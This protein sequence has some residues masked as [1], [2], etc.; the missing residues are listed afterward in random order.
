MKLIRQ[1]SNFK[2]LRT[3]ILFGFISVIVCIL[4]MSGINYSL[5]S[6]TN[7]STKDML[8]IDLEILNSNEDTVTALL[9]QVAAARGYLLSGDESYKDMFYTYGEKVPELRDKVMSLVDHKEFNKNYTR[10]IEWGS[11]VEENVLNVYDAGNEELALKNMRSVDKELTEIRKKYEELAD[12]R[13]SKIKDTGDSIIK[14]GD[15]S[16]ILSF[17]ITFIVIILST[18]IALLTAK[19]ITSPINRITERMKL[20]AEGDVSLPELEVLSRDEVGTLTKAVNM[21]S[22][23]MQ[24]VLFKIQD[25]SNHV[26][27]NSEELTQSASEIKIGAE[28][29]ALTMHELATGTEAQASNASDLATVMIEFS[30]KIQEANASGMEIE[31]NTDDLLKLAHDG[32]ELMAYSTSQM[33]KIDETVKESVLKIEGLNEQTKEI[34]QLVS[35]INDIANQTNLLALN[36]A[37]EAAR[38]GEHGKG[39]AVVADEVRKL[40]EQVSSSVSHISQIVSKIQSESNDVTDSLRIGYQ[41]VENGSEKISQTNEKFN[42]INVALNSIASNIVNVTT[43]LRDIEANSLTINN[44]VDEIASISQESAAG[45]EETSA[46]VEETSSSMD[47][48]S[49][50]SNQLAIMA[51]DLSMQLSKFKV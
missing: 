48:I 9:V 21:M 27:S 38:A 29:V 35:V 33:K 14:S 45:L 5:T 23:N 32:Q 30:G 15:S 50:S 36:A 37:I 16:I 41:Q 2:K 7:K 18:V 1:L 26:A 34:S 46:T 20:V 51:E 13:F 11:Y 44:A 22:K 17:V 12:A 8:H 28:Q 10:A 25:V 43:S 47:E 3:K 42:D 6:K 4:V 31:K 39:F 24:E 19:S 40:A 49:K